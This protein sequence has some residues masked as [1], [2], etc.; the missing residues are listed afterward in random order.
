FH[1]GELPSPGR[2]R[3]RVVL[4]LGQSGVG[5]GNESLDKMDA[6]GRRLDKHLCMTRT[7]NCHL[8]VRKKQP[9]GHL[10][11]TSTGVPYVPSAVAVHECAL[12]AAD[13]YVVLPHADMDVVHFAAEQNF[14][15]F[16]WVDRYAAPLRQY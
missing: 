4:R 8:L 2:L 6:V 12:M 13:L 15:T 10:D 11:H 1:V 7:R 3:Y 5:T 9:A 16:P 14:A